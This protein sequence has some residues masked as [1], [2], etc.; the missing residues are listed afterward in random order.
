[1]ALVVVEVGPVV[2][3]VVVAV[4]V[5]GVVVGS[6][7]VEGGVAVVLAVVGRVVVVVEAGAGVVTA[8][9]SSSSLFRLRIASACLGPKTSLQS[10]SL[11]D[12][13]PIFLFNELSV[14]FFVITLLERVNWFSSELYILEAS[15]TFAVE[16]LNEN[17]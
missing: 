1:M 6:V 5:L 8:V 16:G 3:A 12:T 14:R 11:Y 17:R 7:A 2:L 9:V 10:G 13:H 15:D 4:A